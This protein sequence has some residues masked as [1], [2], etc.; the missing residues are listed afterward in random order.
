MNRGMARSV[1][2]P[3]TIQ[4]ALQNVNFTT[5]I[6]ALIAHLV[7]KIEEPDREGRAEGEEEKEEVFK[8][9]EII[10]FIIKN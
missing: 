1:I 4:V 2:Q 5:A 7:L 9:E 3:R 6:M 10:K 8:I